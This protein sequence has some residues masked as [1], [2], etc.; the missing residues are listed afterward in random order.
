MFEIKYQ[1]PLGLLGLIYKNFCKW[2]EQKLTHYIKFLFR[3]IYFSLK[4]NAI[5]IRD[6]YILANQISFLINLMK[7]KELKSENVRRNHKVEN[8]Q[9]NYSFKNKHSNGS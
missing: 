5:E 8:E 6:A 2:N 4:N 9:N 7:S 3:L 1:L